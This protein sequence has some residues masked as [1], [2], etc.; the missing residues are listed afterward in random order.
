MS[1][2]LT[3]AQMLTIWERGLPLR[4]TERA[5]LT[6]SIADPL[7]SVD[8]A[9]CWPLGRRDARLLEMREATFGGHVRLAADCPS[10]G[11]S[12]EIDVRTHDL[13][14]GEASA[15]TV[16]VD[17]GDLRV[18]ARHPTSEDLAAAEREECES[19]AQR[20]LWQRCVET[21]TS[22]GCFRAAEV[23]S[24]AQRE[25]IETMLEATDPRTDVA[26]D[27]TC[28]DCGERWAA[29][30]DLARLTWDEVARGARA[31]FQEIATLARGFG[32]TEDEVLRLS[33]E[34]RAIYCGL[35]EH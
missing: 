12:L 27:V 31:I 5:L 29:P 10:C 23:L 8:E 28:I 4:P 2:A 16:A 34:R 19:A 15:A 14:S 18:V 35:L 6:L 20:L 26:L 32:W 9:R 21:A 30:C 1:H 22:D 3:D 24:A 13:R 25:Q 11:A 33:R 17:F 7:L